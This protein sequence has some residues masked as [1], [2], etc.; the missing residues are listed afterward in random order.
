VRSPLSIQSRDYSLAFLGLWGSK[1]PNPAQTYQEVLDASSVKAANALPVESVV[2]EPTPYVGG[3]IPEPPPILDESIVFNHLGEATLQSL[4]LGSWSPPGC[5][6]WLIEQIHINADLP[7]YAS[8]IGLAVVMRTL[9][10]PVVV[11][12]QKNA[13]FLRK[14]GPGMAKFQNKIEDAKA[15]GNKLEGRILLAISTV[16]KI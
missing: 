8:I 2:A 14:A 3:Y 1:K 12:S 10:F 13:A 6:Q 11:K 15:S 5:M 9:L 4:G 16:I 7:W